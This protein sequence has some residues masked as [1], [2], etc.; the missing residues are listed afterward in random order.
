MLVEIHRRDA[1]NAEGAQRKRFN[2]LRVLR[3]S[4]RL[5]G[6]S[7]SSLH[8]IHDSTATEKNES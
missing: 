5:C 8:S 3:V 4:L 1:E 7:Q 2:S 6:E